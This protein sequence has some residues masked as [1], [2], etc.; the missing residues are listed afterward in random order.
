MTVVAIG[1]STWFSFRS[2]VDWTTRWL[3]P[4]RRRLCRRRAERPQRHA[5]AVGCVR[6]PIQT[7]YVLLPL[8]SYRPAFPAFP[9]VSGLAA[10]TRH[11]S[12]PGPIPAVLFYFLEAVMTR[13]TTID[14]LSSRL[15]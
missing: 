8:D 3:S 4:A 5:K 13:T 12:V 9:S 14:Q 6:L 11:G 7:T 10:R 15:A 2:R 1:S